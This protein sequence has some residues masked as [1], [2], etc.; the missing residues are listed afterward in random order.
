MQICTLVCT[1]YRVYTFY[2]VYS[3]IQICMY[4]NFA[5]AINE[6][7]EKHNRSSSFQTGLLHDIKQLTNYPIIL[8]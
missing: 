3:Y 4:N 5:L 2:T 1:V 8:S 7:V 6:C